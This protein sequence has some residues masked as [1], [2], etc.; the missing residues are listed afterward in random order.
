MLLLPERNEL[1]HLK[2]SLDPSYGLFGMIWVVNIGLL[3]SIWAV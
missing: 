3:G 2:G 1:Y